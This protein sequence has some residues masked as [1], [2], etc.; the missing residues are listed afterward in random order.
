LGDLRRGVLVAL[1]ANEAAP[2]ARRCGSAQPGRSRLP[3]R[4]NVHATA[5]FAAGPQS[6]STDQGD[7]KRRSAR[8]AWRSTSGTP[9]SRGGQVITRA[10]AAPT[11]PL[12]P[13]AGHA[14]TAVPPYEA[15]RRA[16]GGRSRPSRAFVGE[17]TDDT[18]TALALAWGK[19][20]LTI[21]C[22]VMRYVFRAKL[23][24]L[25]PLNIGPICAATRTTSPSPLDEEG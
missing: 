22:D 16:R 24:C 23:F 25:S 8:P 2:I 18:G 7:G 12:V 10:L 17:W 4:A 13:P 21:A 9:H 6:P 3:T 5:A 19:G 1:P 11:R 20:P 15:P 14:A